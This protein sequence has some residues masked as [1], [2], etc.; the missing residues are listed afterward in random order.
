MIP[1]L[2]ALDRQMRKYRCVGVCVCGCGFQAEIWIF[3]VALDASGWPLPSAGGT[4]QGRVKPNHLQQTQYSVIL[5]P[6]GSCLCRGV[7]PCVCVCVCF[8][9]ACSYVG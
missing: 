8:H 4:I 5:E 9:E 3:K 6:S 1:L 7:Y 2:T